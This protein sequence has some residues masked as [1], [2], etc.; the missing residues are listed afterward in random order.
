MNFYHEHA[1][2]DL[3]A[4]LKSGVEAAFDEIYDRY[5]KKLYNEAYKRL[6]NAEL[7]EE[8]V[9]DVFVDLWKNNAQRDI[10]QLYP[11]LLTATRYQVFIVYKKLKSLPHFEEPLE[12]MA[13]S[14]QGADA[15][16]LE[17]DLI[18]AI[19]DW[20]ET[21]PEKRRKIFYLKYLEGM[22]TREIAQELNI[23]QKTVQN[24][25]NISQDSLRSSI[26]KFFL[27]FLLLF[28]I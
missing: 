10:Q 12:N 18:S 2:Q 27:A 17:K 19:N 21:Q 1:D 23:S 24:Q 8:V 22:P 3:T 14:H 4:L 6:Q 13:V 9:Q 15:F 7:S 16:C 5:W 25:L 28:Q 20:L 26:L 11:Y